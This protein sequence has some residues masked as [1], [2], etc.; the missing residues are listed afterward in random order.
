[1][2]ELTVLVP[3]GVK[4]QVQESAD[5]SRGDSRIPADRNVVLVGS[6]QL[7]VAVARVEGAHPKAKASVVLMCG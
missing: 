3:K 7:K 2:S 5:L 6:D 1:M 4:V